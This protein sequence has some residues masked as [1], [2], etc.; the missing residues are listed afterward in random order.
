[1]SNLLYQCLNKNLY[2]YGL[3]P[4]YKCFK[5]IYNLEQYYNNLELIESQLFNLKFGHRNRFNTIVKNNIKN[6]YLKHQLTPN[7]EIWKNL[8]NQSEFQYYYHQIKSELEIFELSINK[9]DYKT[10]TI[11]NNIL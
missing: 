11:N 8:L 4:K 2:Y 7:F 1:M 5:I 9:S 6:N 10:L 3:I